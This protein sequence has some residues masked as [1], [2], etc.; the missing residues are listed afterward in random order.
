M[1]AAP[2]TVR[3]EASLAPLGDPVKGQVAGAARLLDEL[4]RVR[5]DRQERDSRFGKFHMVFD[6]PASRGSALRADDKKKNRYRNN[7]LWRNYSR[8][9]FRYSIK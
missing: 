6:P 9:N 2:D 7:I 8:T 1:V 3:D 5:R 4:L